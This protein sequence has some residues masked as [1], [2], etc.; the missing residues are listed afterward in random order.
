[1]KK[2]FQLLLWVAGLCV[3]L[4]MGAAVTIAN[5][6][7]DDYREFI[8]AKVREKTGRDFSLSGDIRLEYYPWLGV[9]VGGLTL[10]NAAGFGEQPFLQTDALKIRA[11]LLPLFR[12][13]IEMDTIQI[14]GARLNLARNKEGKTNWNDLKA[15]T[16]SDEPLPLAALIL[17]GVDI[18]DASLTW[19]DRSA[20]VSWRVSALNATTGSLVLGKPIDLKV[21]LNADVTRPKIS[22]NVALAGTI[23]YDLDDQHY[24]LQPLQLSA[25]LKGQNIPGGQTELR[26]ASA[27]DVNL[28]DDTA[29]ISG[30]QLDA[31]DTHAEGDLAI[32]QL[33]SGKPAL[34]GTLNIKGK[35]LALLFKAFEVEPLA[36][37]VARLPDRSF[38][39]SMGLDADMSRG[40]VDLTGLIINLL[41]AAVKGDVYA[42]NIESATP[43]LKGKLTAGGPDLPALIQIAG[44]FEEGEDSRF[45]SLGKQLAGMKNKAFA[46]TTDFDADLKTGNVDVADLTVNLLDTAIKGNL[47]ARDVQSE[48]PAVKGKLTASGPDLPTLIQIA[49]HFEPGKDSRLK[50]LGKHLA[51][52]KNKAFAV[53]TEFDADLKTG[54]VDVAEMS[55][56][57]FDASIKGNLHTRDVQSETPAVKG[58]LTASGP[59]LPTLIQIAGQFEPEKDSRL[60]SLGKYLAGTKDKSFTVATEF[61][62]DLKTG[63]VDVPDL[64][65]QALGITMTGNLNGRQVQSET[66]AMQ[67]KLKATGPDLPL[68]L[69]MA[70][71]FGEG[72]NPVLGKLGQQLANVGNK[73]FTVETKFDVDMKSGRIN[74]PDLTARAMGI[75]VAGKLEGENI[76]S[77]RGKMAGQLQITGTDLSGVLTA[78][79]QAELA[80][81]LKS[82]VIEAG[83]SGNNQ[84]LHLQPL[85]IK[86]TLSGKQI[87]NS[88]VAVA[89]NAATQVNLKKQTLVL[90][91]LSLSGL[92]LDVK[93]NLNAQ[94][95]IDAP[96][97]DGNL[98]VAPF[99]L[100]QLLKQLNQKPPLTA[101]AKALG[102]VALQTAF[103]GTKTGIDLKKLVL[104]LDDTQLQGDL[105]VLD[106]ANPDIRFG[107]GIDKLNADRYLP[108]GQ[109]G[110]K[111]RPATPETVV[112]GAATELPLETLRALKAKGDLLIGELIISNARLRDVRFSIDAK[113]GNI[114]LAPIAANLYEG[115][116]EG[117]IHLDATGKLPR[118][119]INTALKGIQAEPLLKD[120]TGKADL[121]GTG[122]FSV[123]LI[124]AGNNVGNLKKTLNGQG[125]IRFSKGILRGVD[126]RRMLEQ[127]E[128]MIENKQIGKIEK[129][130]ETPFDQLTGTLTITGGVVNNQDLILTAPGFKVPGK[131]MLINLNDMTWKYDMQVAVDEA[132]TTQGDQRYN[133]GGY[134]IPI[135]C[136]GAVDPD[137]CQPDYGGL[138]AAAG[139]KMVGEKLKDILN[140]KLGVEK[141]QPAQPVAAPTTDVQPPA[142]VQQPAIEQ[143]PATQKAPAKKKKKKPAAPPPP[144]A[145]TIEDKV[146]EELGN[147]LDKL[148][149][150]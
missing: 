71:Y 21:S 47:H 40:D 53:A 148:P 2:L 106:F 89:L 149:G 58:K 121:V 12:K 37:Q 128:I 29:T 11:K 141:Q 90:D 102:K 118:L 120:V 49:G 92:G 6:E 32:G 17:G 126:V 35:D 77:D 114:K 65:M 137:N 138:L 83:I 54:K 36:T 133:L 110:K 87:P 91:S 94:Q 78:V 38:D 26:L 70:G 103:T 146:G 140:K 101:D 131:G 105:S 51:G 113:D 117:D 116:Y 3:I 80:E 99:D 64:S 107:I 33:Q 31:L 82:V 28:D 66:P 16:A 84:D 129:G 46:V 25:V 69:Q 108:P 68:L 145:E 8:T 13:Q 44:Q 139:E 125:E 72:E 144:P 63:N 124:A 60:K 122:D 97:Y 123:A 76:E 100:R 4:I 24:T 127:A 132:S 81:V 45:K 27:L 55:V 30:I 98:V 19:D 20:D 23:A 104:V 95:I 41:G 56:S 93:G 7:P 111:V 134:E 15:E 57:L 9:E 59:D 67:G 62:V 1:M 22:T 115:K 50:T 79:E 18:R 130:G 142:T 150:L 43:A 86:A 52:M 34:K 96:A 14:H 42:R 109:E 39:L 85:S 119:T 73:E 10:G 112:A 61:D 136:R 74:V 5:L 48:T 147:I 143:P 135:K 75:T 88:P